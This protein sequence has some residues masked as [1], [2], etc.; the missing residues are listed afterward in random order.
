MKKKNPGSSVKKRKRLLTV[1]GSK[2]SD[3]S[4]PFLSA[5]MMVKNEEKYLAA[6][7]KSIKD[8]VDEI[9]VVDTGS[10]DKTVEIAESFGAKIYHH[11]WTGDFSL[12]RNQTISYATGKWIFIIDAD[13]ELLFDGP[14]T[15][16]KE[17]LK[18]VPANLDVGIIELK[19]VQKK[20]VVMKFNTARLFRRG[21]V[22]YQGIIHNQPQTKG[23]GVFIKGMYLNHY[24]YD[25]TPEEKQA[26]FDRTSSALHIRLKKNPKDYSCYFYLSQIHANCFE[27]TECVKYGEEYLKHKDEL[28]STGDGNFN[29][30]IYFTV[31]HNYM[32]LGNQEKTKEWLMA[33]LAEVPGDIDLALSA[34]EFGVWANNPELTVSGAKDFISLYDQFI[35]NPMAKLNRFIYSLRPEALAYCTMNLAIVQLKEGTKAIELFNKALTE[36]P[37]QFQSGMVKM[38]QDSLAAE[39]VPVHVNVSPPGEKQSPVAQRQVLTPPTNLSLPQS[40]GVGRY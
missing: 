37:P 26:K 38:L 36:T 9:I 15:V 40:V 32:K 11:P 25:L 31:I 18:K 19:D 4:A 23:G 13:E 24:G 7:L 6:C 39:N 28:K 12:H 14:T 3:K 17:G 33:G 1:V 21:T 34:C 16:M 20:Q 2:P 29:R 5:C 8:I 30:S 35:K 27:H 22:E 10:E